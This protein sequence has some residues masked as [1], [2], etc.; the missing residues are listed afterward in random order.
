MPRTS[1]APKA[2]FKKGR[3]SGPAGP[4][5]GAGLPPAPARRD[6]ESIFSPERRQVLTLGAGG[7]IVIPA[8]FRKKMEVAEGDSIVALLDEDGELRLLGTKAGIR[9]AQAIVRKYVPEGV[10]LVD[11]LIE[12]RR[13]EV[14]EEERSG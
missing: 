7:R 5:E 3:A 4:A 1:T 2:S 6:R 12:D 14:E 10:S 13:R 9:K 8:H 11:E